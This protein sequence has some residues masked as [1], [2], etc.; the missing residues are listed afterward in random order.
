MSSPEFALSRRTFSISLAAAALASRLSGADAS[1]P[2]MGP[3][4]LHKVFLAVPQPTW[5]R[6]DLD[7]AAERAE[8]ERVLNQLEQRHAGD[9]QF[10]GGGLVR[11]VDDALALLRTIATDDDGVLIA[12]LTSGT[13]EIL[14]VLREINLPVLLYARPYSGWSYVDV[15]EW[16]QSG[17]KA[18]LV[19]TSDPREL[20][21]YMKLFRTI[22]HVR[23]SKVL[24]LSQAKA[25]RTAEAYT[26]LFG[27]AF[28]FPG[29]GPKRTRSF[30]LPS[31]SS[32]PAGWRL[33]TPSAC[34][35]RCLES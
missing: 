32:S 23:N 1:L 25:S 33:Q 8:I 20:D 27:T 12:D 9:V 34:M 2:W 3:A 21:L 29:Y 26:K 16:A 4:R 31:G 11:T 19:V 13:G 10:T 18:D 5:P 28:S 7:V 35:T 15:A 6:P 30:E 24:V 14:R 22:H 17:R